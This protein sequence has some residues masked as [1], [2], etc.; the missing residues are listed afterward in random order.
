VIKFG[1]ARFQLHE[2]GYAAHAIAPGK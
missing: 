1:I 2:T